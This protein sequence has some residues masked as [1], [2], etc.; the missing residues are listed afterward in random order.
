M[1]LRP[2]EVLPVSGGS[3]F[4]SSQVPFRSIGH[5]GAAGHRISLSIPLAL[6]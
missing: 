5:L 3:F 6:R 2:W 4:R 1:G